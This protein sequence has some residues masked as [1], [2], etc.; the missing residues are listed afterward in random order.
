VNDDPASRAGGK[1]NPN[2]AAA[3]QLVRSFQQKILACWVPL[4]GRSGKIY[5]DTGFRDSW[6]SGIHKISIIQHAAKAKKR[7]QARGRLKAGG[8][9]TAAASQ[10]P[11]S[12]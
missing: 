7:C 8:Y 5:R 12:V 1:Q 2:G 11:E 3:E 6:Q 9:N 10:Q 4:F